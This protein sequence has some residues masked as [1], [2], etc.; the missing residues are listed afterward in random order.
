MKKHVILSVLLLVSLSF[1]L[2]QA[3]AGQV[4]PNT[5]SNTL[6]DS[7][8]IVIYVVVKKVAIDGATSFDMMQKPDVKKL[9][10]TYALEAK[11]LPKAVQ[12]VK[13]EWK[14]S[15]SDVPFPRIAI[16]VSRVMEL[17]T[18]TDENK[19]K[20]ALKKFTDEWTKLEERK[21][22]ALEK[23]IARMKPDQKAK[24]EADQK[25]EAEA[26][27]KIRDK[28]AAVLADMKAK[29]QEKTQKKTTK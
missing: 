29:E 22:K 8:P 24:Y 28:I 13:K 21:A 27:Q 7:K 6:E 5:N 11:A 1:I 3:A 19:A 12:L 17:G 10:D 25:L 16:G 18:F 14:E 2:P 15:H 20:A 9:Q 26:Y 23:R 4:P